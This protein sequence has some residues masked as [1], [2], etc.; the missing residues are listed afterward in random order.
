MTQEEHDDNLEAFLE[1]AKQCNI[2]YSPEKCEFS[3][4]ELHI[5]GCL[6]KD[7]EIRQYP[8]RL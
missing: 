5:L 1:A 2:I 6:V 7:G 3:L 4:T 8:G